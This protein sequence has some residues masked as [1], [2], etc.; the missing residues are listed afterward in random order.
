MRRSTAV[1]S[2]PCLLSILL[3]ACSGLAA[4]PEVSAVT[5]VPAS[6]DSAWVRAKRALTAE[7]FTLDVQDS[8]GGRLTAMR[9]PSA[10]AKV[11]TPAACRVQLALAIR[12]T[13]ETPEVT[14]TSRWIAPEAM[15]GSD[16][17]MCEKDR[18]ETVD[19]VLAVVAPPPPSQ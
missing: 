1:S 12:G 7:V 14:S 19:R 17:G 13:A 15:A 8:V 6:R 9:Y 16:V 4:G 2:I 10:T 11:G 3:A 5:P 18:Q